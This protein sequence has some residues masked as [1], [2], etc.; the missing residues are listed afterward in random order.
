M[1]IKSV[2]EHAN[3]MLPLA[4]EGRKAPDGLWIKAATEIAND[5]IDQTLIIAHREDA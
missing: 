1:K 3:E 5:A 4:N 2:D